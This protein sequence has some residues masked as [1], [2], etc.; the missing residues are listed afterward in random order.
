MSNLTDLLPAGAGG[1]QVSFVASG[2]IGNGVTVALK[3]DGTVEAVAEAAPSAGTSVVFSSTDPSANIT[4]TYDPD[5][6]KIIIAYRGSGPFNYGNAVVGTVS[7]T[8]ISFGTPVVFV[9]NMISEPGSTYDPTN[10]KVIIAYTSNEAVAYGKAIVGTVSGTSISFGT[11][12]TFG[13]ST[14]SE[15]EAVYDSTNQKVVVTYTDWGN[16]YYGTSKVGTVSGTSISFG[17]AAIFVSSN[18]PGG[19]PTY[20]SS[21]GKVAIAYRLTSNGYGTAVVGTVSGTS[22]SFGSP[23]TFETVSTSYYSITYDTSNSKVVI[24]YRYNS[25]ATFQGRAIVGTVSGTSISFGTAV[26]YL[27]TRTDDMSIS[28]DSNASKVVIAYQDVNN[29]NRGALVVGTVSGTS[30]SFGSPVV[31]ESDYTYAIFSAYDS[32]DNK[33]VISYNSSSSGQSVVFQNA[34][35]NNVDFIG[36]SDAAISDTASG[37]VT[38][39]GGISTNVTGLT[40]NSTYYVQADGALAA[41]GNTPYSIAG[42]TYD[43]INFSVNSQ[44]SSPSDVKFNA[45]GSKMYV[46]SPSAIT[47]YEYDLGTNFDVSSSVYARSK[48]LSAQAVEI[49]AITFNPDGTKMYSL[50]QVSGGNYYIDQYSLSTAFDVSSASYD[51][52]RSPFVL[53]TID[54]SPQNIIFNNDGSKIYMVGIGNDKVYEFPLST[55][56]VISSASNSSGINFSVA[57]QET[58]PKGIAF[59]PTGTQMFIVGPNSDTI[60]QYNLTS[61]FDI[62]TASYSSISYNVNPEEPDPRGFTFN[63]DGTK[64]YIIGG[65]F[66]RG[67]Y[68][69]STT[70]ASTTVLAG[71]ALSS[72]S[73]N[74]DYTT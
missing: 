46:V 68:Q 15:I 43:N 18:F 58:S 6:N 31:F 39:K 3:T 29:S 10:Q 73:I 53:Q 59:N 54:S 36:I 32:V 9:S 67:V 41:S 21:A 19:Q 30:I 42:S 5:T 24:A 34:S 22:I 71:K 56:Y 66:P 50:S 11:A 8:S 52:V 14:S 55:P 62:T 2:T 7:G 57:S 64:F 61:G 28:Y 13:A 69:Y 74:L 23:V 48:S 37:S 38:I 60:F 12:T 27:S 17:T 4:S 51:S 70:S 20:D 49:Y 45:D 16:N 33:T 25:G 40:P 63:S 44:A 47:I 72:T 26:V 1:K 65:V 35:S